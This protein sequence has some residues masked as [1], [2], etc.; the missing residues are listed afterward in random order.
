MEGLGI[1]LGNKGVEDFTFSAQLLKIKAELKFWKPVK[2][3][4]TGKIKVL[5]IYIYSGLWYHTEFYDITTYILSELNR[6]TT[7]F[8]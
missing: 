1:W 3:S 2:I 6:E 4:L 8:I 5:N 7:D